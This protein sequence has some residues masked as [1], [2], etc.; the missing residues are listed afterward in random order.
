MPKATLGEFQLY[1]EEH[2]AGEPLLLVLPSWWTCDTWKVGVLPRLAEGWRTII[3][4]NRGA[5]RSG[6]PKG[7]YRVPQFARDAADLLSNLGIPRCHVAGFALGGTVAEAL[8]I[9][10]PDL[11]AT[12]TLAGVGPGEL[13]PPGSAAEWRDEREIREQGFER[14]IR[15]HVE[16]DR[17]AFSS[18]FYRDH[19]DTV[20]AL[21]DA[22]WAGQTEP[23]HLR[24]HHE[25]RST[26]DTLFNAPRVAM[27]TLVLCGS[28]D[29][30]AR[31]K[32]SSPAAT[33]RRL[34]G[35]IADAELALVPEV[36]HMT[37]WDGDGALSRFTEFLARHPIDKL[38]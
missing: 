33:A 10:R 17:T 9:E 29:D 6:R 7:G 38:Q 16:N 5:G 4:D 36:R 32:N 12:L 19:I 13:A 28:A 18:A 31:G 23:E 3:F 15:A 21:G 22:L 26:W 20:K 1:Y 24:G 25:A 14:Y 34:A 27:K 37:F 30:V 35:L 2:G 8:A 11:V